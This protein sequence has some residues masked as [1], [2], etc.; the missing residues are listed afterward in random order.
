MSK[1]DR[2]E[3]RLTEAERNW[4]SDMAESAA[5]SES[6]YVRCLINDFSPKIKRLNIDE[7][8]LDEVS[9]ELKRIG[10][11]LN[12]LTR[13]VNSGVPVA[14]E[15]MAAALESHHAVAIKL[16]ELIE[17]TRRC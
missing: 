7:S 17:E 13:R 8:R 12:Q 4:L 5:M 2:F 15:D 3:I 1:T 6:Q 9:R 11:N 14:P 10:S 16:S